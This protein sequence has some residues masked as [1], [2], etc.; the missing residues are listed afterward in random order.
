M[1][2]IHALVLPPQVFLI[3]SGVAEPILL[4]AAESRRQD[5]GEEGVVAAGLRGGILGS[6]AIVVRVTAGEATV[7]GT[8]VGRHSMAPAARPGSLP[9]AVA[10]SAPIPAPAPL[11]A[12]IAA[13]V[14]PITSAVVVAALTS[15]LITT[16]R[17]VVVVSGVVSPA[18]VRII[19]TA[20]VGISL[21]VATAAATVVPGVVVP[22]VAA[23]ASST[24]IVV[25]ALVTS[26]TPLGTLVATTIPVV[27]G[28]VTITATVRHFD[29]MNR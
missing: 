19:L 29:R 12:V 13:T 1:I 8:G 24:P 17:G 4:A 5:L 27:P 14:T 7:R 3:H 28:I 22:A 11:P 6:T 25:G 16:R 9:V 23:V 20:I 21:A 10:V 2:L 26:V 15:V 18:G